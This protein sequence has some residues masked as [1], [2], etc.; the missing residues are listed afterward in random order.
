MNIRT[1]QAKN[2]PFIARVILATN[3]SHIFGQY[4][5]AYKTM[6]YIILQGDTG[7]MGIKG[8]PGE[9]GDEVRKN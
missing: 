4:S 2:T 6:L 1:I 3:I 7:F 8:P 9:P 5:T